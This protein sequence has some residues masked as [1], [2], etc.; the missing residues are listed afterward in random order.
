MFSISISISI[1][2]VLASFSQPGDN[3]EV[4]SFAAPVRLMAGDQPMGQGRFYPSPSLVDL[5]GDGVA[6]MVIGD[7]FGKLTVSKRI[8]GKDSTAWSAPEPLE[9]ADGK[10]L[11][12]NNW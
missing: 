8:P 2:L 5:D 3:D 7:L 12:F 11:K 1:P 9:G 6:E 10:P 4:P